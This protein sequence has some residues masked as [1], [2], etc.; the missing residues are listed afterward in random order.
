[1][2]DMSSPLRAVLCA[3]ESGATTRAEL[4]EN[5]GLCAD[6]VDAALEHLV[7]LGRI[8]ATTIS[9]GCPDGGCGACPSSGGCSVSG[10]AVGRPALVSLSVRRPS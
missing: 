3:L 5:T 1:M 8:E 10:H 6:V 7:R 2:A 4:Q 9:V